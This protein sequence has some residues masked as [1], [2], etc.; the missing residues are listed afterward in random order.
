MGKRIAILC[1]SLNIGGA[2][3]HIFELA[4]G[5]K[6]KGHDVT[7]F[8]NGGVY[9][10]AMEQ[11]GIRH[12]CAPLNKK[13]PA[14]LFTSYRLIK[15]E[16]KKNRPSVIHSHTRISNYVGGMVGRRLG[17]PLV[18]TVHFNFKVN[19]LIRLFSRWGCRALAVSEDLKEYLVQ[20]YRYNPDHVG[21][22]V[23]GIDVRR[24]SRRDSAAFRA[25][26]GIEP[27]QKMILM[28]SR[29]DKE[30]AV[31]VAHFL[32]LAPMIHQRDPKIRLVIVGDG[33]I[34]EELSRQAEEYNRACG[35]RFILMQGGRTNIDDYTAAAD[36]FV[37]VSRS[38]LEA[39]SSSVPTILLGNLGYL[40][41]Y[42]EAVRQPCI[43]TNLTC[44]GYEFPPDQTI[45]SLVLECLNG[46]DLTFNIRDGRRLV[47]ECYSI[48][49]MVAT[50]EKMYELASD[51]QRPLD[52]MISGYYGSDNFGDN[53]TLRCLMEHLEN[54]R[55]SV[56]THNIHNTYVPEKVLKVHRFNLPKISRLMRKTKV[57]L[58]GSG[59]ILQDS[60][61][62]RSFFYYYFITKMAIRRHCK[63]LLYANG[64]GPIIREQNKKR[65]AWLLNQVD[66]I[67]VRDQESIDLLRQLKVQKPAVLTAD[68]SF[69]F[70]FSSIAPHP[71]VPGA[72]GKTIVGVNF[73]L[74]SGTPTAV[75]QDL[76][77]GLSILAEKYNLFY[78]LLPFHFSQDYMQLQ[79]LHRLLPENS[80]IV[81]ATS[82]PRQLAPYF[83]A[84]QY[85]IFERLHAQIMATMLGTPFLP[86][87]YDPKNYALMTQIG[88]SD[89]LLSHA[90]LSGDNLVRGFEKILTD[91][92]IIRA[93]LADY[94]QKAREKTSLNKKYLKQMIKDY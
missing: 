59:S 81:E 90:E 45:I 35:E 48:E 65:A 27:D 30:A 21:L 64:I 38:A 23:N 4:R 47:E 11:A 53:L 33:K 85:Q 5:L 93:K 73:K 7:V 79:R 10:E 56:L 69:S 82:E 42:S 76:G 18:T 37:G 39:M 2:E 34:R 70:D 71:P 60:T 41:L 55:G 36:L 49:A 25:G 62:S 86:I 61:S 83:S 57:F 13:S 3:T 6:Q 87:H 92:D 51:D 28:V 54:N 68:D 16:C 89:Y 15:R 50:N 8:S 20:N 80:Y 77:E 17:I 67:T 46:K 44:R 43:E 91:Q 32:R 94:T 31:H 9:A 26:L 14:A 12:I 75:I 88:L 19:S 24:F 78:Y 22:T 58:L 66:F 72:E 1:M 63:T 40:G 84:T 29:L 74:D 52:Y